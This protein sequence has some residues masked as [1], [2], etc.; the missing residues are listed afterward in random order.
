MRPPHFVLDDLAGLP[1]V[2]DGL[3]PTSPDGICHAWR[4]DPSLSSLDRC[5]EIGGAR[6]WKAT[7]TACRW[8]KP[9]SVVRCRNATAS[10]SCSSGGAAN[11]TVLA[12]ATTPQI[13]QPSFDCRSGSRF[14]AGCLPL[15][16]PIGGDGCGCIG[17]A[18]S[19]RLRN[20]GLNRRRRLHDLVKV[21]ERKRRLDRERKQRQPRTV[22]D[23]R[24]EPLHV[25][26]YPAS[27]VPGNPGA[28]D[29]IL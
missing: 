27:R 1:S 24:P 19:I 17:R 7:R 16:G 3:I 12:M 9:A 29:V 25:D 18:S 15:N 8:M 22:S 5:Q 10:G 26:V 6:G 23:I 28:S 11:N 14:G 4:G 20:S 13:A 21:A 2:I